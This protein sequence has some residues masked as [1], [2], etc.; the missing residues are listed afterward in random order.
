MFFVEALLLLDRERHLVP[1][2]ALAGLGHLE[3]VLVQ[4]VHVDLVLSAEYVVFKVLHVLYAG[5]LALVKACGSRI[6]LST[7]LLRELAQVCNLEIALGL[8]VC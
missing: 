2:E 5:F 8:R 6:L 7:C 1:V 3:V 4:L